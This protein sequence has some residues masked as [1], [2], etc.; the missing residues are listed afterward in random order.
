MA[1][2]PARLP[3][4]PKRPNHTV[5]KS[6]RQVVANMT[7]AGISRTEIA[8]M[9]GISVRTLDTYYHHELEF[10]KAM[11][12]AAVAGTM[13]DVA[14]N[15]RHPNW[16]QAAKHIMGAIGSSEWKP[17]S[18]VDVNVNVKQGPRVIDPAL[19]TEEEREALSEIVN[20]ALA[21]EEDDVRVVDGEV[22]DGDVVEVEAENAYNPFD[23]FDVTPPKPET[24]GD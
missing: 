20:R 9:M 19:L 22:V 7:T 3:P 12:R 23:L 14:L 15:P 4:P 10:H 11:V 13:T 5:T 16:F 24:A 8:R 2:V 21:E 6:T 1:I 17:N 18:V